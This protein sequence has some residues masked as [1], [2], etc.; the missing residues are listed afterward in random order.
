MYYDGCIGDKP[1]SIDNV[2]K[3]FRTSDR[4]DA[5]HA[6]N[7]LIKWNLVIRKSAGYGLQVSLNHDRIADIQKIIGLE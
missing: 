7:D 5:K 6:L 2:I 1:T 4:G 3:G